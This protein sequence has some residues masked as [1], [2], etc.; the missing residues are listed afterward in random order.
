[1]T[2]KKKNIKTVVDF[3]VKWPV[4]NVRIY[5]RKIF[6]VSLCIRTTLVTETHTAHYE[7]LLM[8]R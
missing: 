7:M 2:Q 4:I 8:Y 3:A 6:F 1:M 5:N